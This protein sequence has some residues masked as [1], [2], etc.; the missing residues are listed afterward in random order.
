MKHRFLQSP[1][2]IWICHLINQ[3]ISTSSSSNQCKATLSLRFAVEK[4]MQSLWLHQDLYIAM[5]KTISDNW[6]NKKLQRSII[7]QQKG[8][9][10]M[11]LRSQQSF[12]NFWILKSFQ[13][14]VAKIIQSL[15]ALH[16]KQ[17]HKPFKYI[18][19]TM[20]FSLRST[21]TRPWFMFG[22]TILMDSWE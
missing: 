12:S 14:H 1:L 8:E 11:L 16:E 13:W 15:L 4:A 21:K 3:Y 10:W 19:Q 20:R 18:L 17:W 22:E 5:G 9:Q 2:S 7:T 6:V